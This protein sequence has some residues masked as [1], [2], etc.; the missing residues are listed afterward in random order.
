MGLGKTILAI[1]SILHEKKE[2]TVVICPA[3]LKANWHS[4]LSKFAP[5]LKTL[6]VKSTKHFQKMFEDKTIQVF[7]ISFSLLDFITTELKSN[8][9]QMTIA[10]EAHYLK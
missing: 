10:D 8:P 6:I 9:F 5:T 1:A 2:R 4:E 7:I 3:A